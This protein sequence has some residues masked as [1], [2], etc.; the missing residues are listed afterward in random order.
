LIKLLFL[1]FADFDDDTKVQSKSSVA[2][3]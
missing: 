1:S 2:L 3:G